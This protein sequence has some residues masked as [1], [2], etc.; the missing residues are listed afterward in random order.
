MSSPLG[1]SRIGQIAVTVRD[2]SR[3]IA[4]YKDILELPHLFTAGPLAFFN[5]GG[6]RLMLSV[7]E[8]PELN[9]ASSILYFQ[10]TDI[11]TACDTLTQRGVR[12]EDNPHLIARMPDH[13]LWMA[14]F[15]DSEHNLLALMSEVPRPSG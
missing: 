3:A 9:H 4:F 8:K 6:V 15:R 1:L 13:D 11:R 10:V 2:V 14:F 5:C 12:F 7:P